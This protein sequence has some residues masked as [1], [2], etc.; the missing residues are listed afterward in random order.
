MY[1]LSNKG[2]ICLCNNKLLNMKGIDVKKILQKNHY[3]LKV[4]AE[5]MGETQQNFHAMLKVEDIKTG[6]LERIAKA[7]DKNV[8]FFFDEAN[9]DESKLNKDLDNII[10]NKIR[11]LQFYPASILYFLRHIEESTGGE[12]FDKK[13]FKNEDA[14]PK[15]FN[16]TGTQYKVDG[17]T[18]FSS[19]LFFHSYNTDEKIEFIKELDDAVR[20]YFDNIWDISRQTCNRITDY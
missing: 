20:A 10:I 9:V 17:K 1:N 4:I 2:Y 8:L 15:Q 3:S 11:C 5:N 6:V 12:K 14:Y 7:I 16:I 18:F 19:K 13:Q